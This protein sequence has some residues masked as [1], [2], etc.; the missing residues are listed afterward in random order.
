LPPVS[1]LPLRSRGRPSYRAPR[2]PV[3]VRPAPPIYGSGLRIPPF[4]GLPKNNVLTLLEKHA[5]LDPTHQKND[6]GSGDQHS[7]KLP[8][9]QRIERQPHGVRILLLVSEHLGSLELLHASERADL[10]KHANPAGVV[11]QVSVIEG[12]QVHEK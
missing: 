8:A 7:F 4:G 11:I 5:V 10:A 6:L 2:P 1:G 12:R 3:R 9:E